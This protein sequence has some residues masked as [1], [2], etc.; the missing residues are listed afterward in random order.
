M[1]NKALP[2]G[3]AKKPGKS[4]KEKKI[5]KREKKDAQVKFRKGSI[6]S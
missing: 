5:A 1:A 3:Q 4:A 6:G 2:S